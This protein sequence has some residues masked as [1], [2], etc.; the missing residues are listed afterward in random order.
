[1]RPR[2]FALLY[3]FFLIILFGALAVAATM[4]VRPVGMK[5]DIHLDSA[6]A[7]STAEDALQEALASLDAGR[8]APFA[9][10]DG[11]GRSVEVSAEEVKEGM[12]LTV[13]AKLRSDAPG[14]APAGSQAWME[15]CLRVRARKDSRGIWRVLEFEGDPVWSRLCP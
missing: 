5:L 13:T 1:M 10:D 8:P 3:V 9:R 7:H 15:A 4:L 14:V 11:A 6:R 12:R 2:G